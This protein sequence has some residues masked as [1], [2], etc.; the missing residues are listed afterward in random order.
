MHAMIERNQGLH[1]LRPTRRAAFQWTLGLAAGLRPVVAAAVA[2]EIL[3]RPIPRS[4]EPLPV[5][6]L[7]TAV[8]FDIGDN[9]EKRA[10]LDVVL[11]TL[12]AGGGKLVDTAS[13]YGNAE[14][15]LGQLFAETG[16]RQRL[17]VAS[18]VEAR[19]IA[20]CESCAASGSS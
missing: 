4:N 14:S 7:G 5:V 11:R 13:S 1:G 16:L 3:T 15:V 10:A 2:P 17:F 19:S 9:T 6:G 8:N 12:A 20:P 18:K